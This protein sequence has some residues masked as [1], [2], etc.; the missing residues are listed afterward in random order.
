MAE[1]G[2]RTIIYDE[3]DERVIHCVV[4]KSDVAHSALQS[5]EDGHIVT[6]CGLDGTEHVIIKSGTVGRRLCEKCEKIEALE[7][8]VAVERGLVQP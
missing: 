8:A 5:V 4:G 1:K 7:L 2:A 3:S 6:L